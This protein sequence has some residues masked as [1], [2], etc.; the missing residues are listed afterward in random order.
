[1]GSLGGCLLLLHGSALPYGALYTGQAQI[2]IGNASCPFQPQRSSPKG[3]FVA[4][5]PLPPLAQALGSAGTVAPVNLI[6][7]TTRTPLFKCAGCTVSY[8]ASLQASATLAFTH[9]R[10]AAGDTVTIVGVGEWA[11]LEDSY[12]HHEQVV[13]TI[14]GHDALPRYPS[15]T[16]VAR[17]SAEHPWRIELSLPPITAGTH[18][19][20]VAL[21]RLWHDVVHAHGTVALDGAAEATVT[22]LPAITSLGTRRSVHIGQLVRVH[23]SGFSREPHDNA[24]YFG[25]TPCAIVSATLNEL[26]CEVGTHSGLDANATGSAPHGTGPSGSAGPG[27]SFLETPLD[28]SA[29]DCLSNLTRA[30]TTAC[31]HPDKTS[32]LVHLRQQVIFPQYESS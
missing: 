8:S 2:M 13:A 14:D 15:S 3:E 23:G 9:L 21:D 17:P 22:V 19:L 18:T 6:E 16:A 30:R 11:L 27:L 10:G 24:V 25:A 7:T 31:N 20:R 4:C 5:G 12:G 29:R 28:T 26:W 1:M 32:H